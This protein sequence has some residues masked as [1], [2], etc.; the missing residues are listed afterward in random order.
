MKSPSMSMKGWS[1]K[2]WLKGNLKTIKEAVKVG[3]PLVVGWYATS[4]PEL[5]A[6]ITLGGK[7]LL[8]S[9]EY[10]VKAKK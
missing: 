7:L 2:E 6:L 8:D 4:N 9:I 5:T 1:L 10:Y 3:V